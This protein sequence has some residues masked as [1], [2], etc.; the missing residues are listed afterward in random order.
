MLLFL[1]KKIVILVLI[2]LVIVDFLGSC[3]FVLFLSHKIDS[4]PEFLNMETI[5]PGLLGFCIGFLSLVSNGLR[6]PLLQFF[7]RKSCIYPT[8]FSCFLRLVLTLSICILV[9]LDYISTF[10]SLW[11]SGKSFFP[12]LKV[13]QDFFY[14]LEQDPISG[15]FILI[16]TLVI[17]GSPAWL[18]RFLSP[19]TLVRK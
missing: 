12:H 19:V 6:K 17:S 8:D 18:V 10:F 3:Y 13:S 2:L 14:L 4:Q 5:L 7:S 15:L 11:M 16:L 9:F 1:L